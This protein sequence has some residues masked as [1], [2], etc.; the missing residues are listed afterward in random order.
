MN[1]KTWSW[2]GVTLPLDIRN[3]GLMERIEQ[4]G[5][6]LRAA[7][8]AMPK[9]GAAA[10]N[11]RRNYDMFAAFFRTVF[12]GAAEPLFSD[13]DDFG[14]LEDAY[15]DLMETICARIGETA[16]KRAELAEKYSPERLKK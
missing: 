13:P 16:R 9:A 10:E 1:E 15:F 14:A 11:M 2:G 4:A 7:A 12:G 3:I 6:N 5:G 8:A